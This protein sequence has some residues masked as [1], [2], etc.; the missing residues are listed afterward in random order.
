[1]LRYYLNN[2]KIAMVNAISITKLIVSTI[3]IAMKKTSNNDNKE[4]KEILEL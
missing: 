4:S 2:N 3:A 1:M